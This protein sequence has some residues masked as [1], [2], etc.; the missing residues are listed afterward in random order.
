MT[1]TCMCCL[2]DIPE[3]REWFA[4]HYNDGPNLNSA[5]CPACK[6]IL[7]LQARVAALEADAG[8]WRK[9]VADVERGR[10]QIERGEFV[11]AQEALAKVESDA[12]RQA[13]A[14]ER[15]A[16]ARLVC[17]KTRLM[18]PEVFAA[19]ANLAAAIRVRGE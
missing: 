1:L 8:H 2:G 15:E 6:K 17:P 18:P 4:D 9:F 12:V 3:G 10:Q 16:I 19:L 11:A 14:A 13:V 7:E 5:V